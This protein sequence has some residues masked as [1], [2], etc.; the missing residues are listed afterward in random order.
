MTGREIVVAWR[1][2][3]QSPEGQ[4]CS[5]ARTLGRVDPERYLINRLERS[6]HAGIAAAD[7]AAL[8]V[9]TPDEL[10]WLRQAVLELREP[11]STSGDNELGRLIAKLLR[12]EG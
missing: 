4:K 2:W 7:R 8:E 12:E 11:T 9:L 1:K 6:F 5:D 10:A 3:L